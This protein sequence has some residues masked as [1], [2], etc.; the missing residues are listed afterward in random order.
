M[1]IRPVL[2][3]EGTDRALGTIDAL[4]VGGDP[5]AVTHLVIARMGRVDEFVVD[6]ASGVISHLIVHELHHLLHRD[7]RV[8]IA[9]IGHQ[10]DDVLHL[11]VAR[12][13]LARRDRSTS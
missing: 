9:A 2:T 12:S 13:Q 11:N 10:D 5:P 3:V 8:P 6:A 7:L 1:K 4:T